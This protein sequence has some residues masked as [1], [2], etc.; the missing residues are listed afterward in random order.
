MSLPNSD[1]VIAIVGDRNTDPVPS[2]H[3]EAAP[4]WNAVGCLALSSWMLRQSLTSL[5]T[6]LKFSCV[7]PQGTVWSD[8]SG[9]VMKQTINL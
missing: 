2:G 9:L 7:R 6:Y 8:W 3:K 4:K 1:L 5:V